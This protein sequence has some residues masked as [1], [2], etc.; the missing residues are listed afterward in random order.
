MDVQWSLNILFGCQFDSLQ[1]DSETG[2]EYR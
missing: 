1:E 2:P